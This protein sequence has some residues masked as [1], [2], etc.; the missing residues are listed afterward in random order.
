MTNSLHDPDSLA[1]RL[2]EQVP[3][4]RFK[5]VHGDTDPLVDMA[6]QMA[7]TQ[8]P[9]LSAAAMERIRTQVM[10]AHL[11]HHQKRPQRLRSVSHWAAIAS[12]V[13]LLFL[14]GL[15]PTALASVPGDPLYGFKKAIEWGELSAARSVEAQAFTH[16]LHASRR[17]QEAA[18]LSEQGQ[19]ASELFLASLG[20]MAAAAELAHNEPALSGVILDQLQTQT[21]QINDLLNS[22]LNRVQ[23][24]NLTPDTLSPLLTS[25][26]ATQS[27]DSLLL[28]TATPSPAT[29]P[30]ATPVPPTTTSG[31]HTDE[32]EEPD[33]D[34]PP[35]PQAPAEGWRALCEGAPMP[36]DD[37]DDNRGGPGG[38]GQPPHAGPPDSG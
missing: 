26:W 34:N 28:P 10:T 15:G 6:A 25:V 33:C 2:D 29:L 13:L 31:S 21:I 37:P 16:L 23:Q 5:A 3:A 11:N 14:F 4:N 19:I 35:P 30:T 36:Q 22:T 12:L 38:A 32:D 18:K 8:H 20:E 1:R 7:N 24:A 17:A 9:E 27:S